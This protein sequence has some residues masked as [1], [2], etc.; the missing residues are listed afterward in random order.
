MSKVFADP[1]RKTIEQYW[2]GTNLTLANVEFA[3]QN[4]YMDEETF[5]ACM[6]GLNALASELEPAAKVVPKSLVGDMNIPQ[7]AELKKEG[8]LV[9]VELVDPSEKAKSPRQLAELLRVENLRTNKAQDELFKSIRA[10]LRKDV[11]QDKSYVDFV[12]LGAKM[13]EEIKANPKKLDRQP[14][15]A[16]KFINRMI[17]VYDAHGRIEPTAMLKDKDKAVDTSFVGIGT[18]VQKIGT[19]II[20]TSLLDG[21]PAKDSKLIKRND[22][23]LEVDGQSVE[24]LD[25]NKV[26]EKIRGAEG[27]TV[28]LLLLRK[29]EKI[30]VQ[31]T[32]G[33]VE[34]KNVD[35]KIISGLNSEKI[36]YLSLKTFSDPKACSKVDT[37]LTDLIEKG[38]QSL[39]LDLRGNP[40]GYLHHALCI[41]GLFVGDR[42]IVQVKDLEQGEQA[43]LRPLNSW[44][45][46][47]TINFEKRVRVAKQSAHQKTS[48]PMVVLIDADSASASEIISGALQDY[49]RAW[50]VG[51][52]TFGKG[53]VQ[54]FEPDD[55]NKVTAIK[56]IERFYRPSGITNQIVGVQADFVAPIK[57]NSTED[58]LFVA[59]EKD[60]F[61][62]S[63]PPVGSVWV[64]QR[65][66][67]VT[68][69]QTC[70]NKGKLSEQLYEKLKDDT[71][72]DEV[73]D[74]QLLNAKEVLFCDAAT[75]VSAST[76]K[77]T[78]EELKGRQL[79]GGAK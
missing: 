68:R 3:A 17:S 72:S 55:L 33:K 51:E 32:R 79:S 19:Q 12:T 9:Y 15:I 25:L 28:Q 75:A 20:V 67:D 59:R 31:I 6:A 24:G 42:V 58:E 11:S 16:A 53:S 70:L 29:S 35:G 50:L 5:R 46:Q 13:V 57:P 22:V 56:T 23:V 4:C 18:G 14:L 36:G 10:S 61:P 41:G 78:P 1:S 7:G 39:I 54:R 48:L 66:D 63:L 8:S 2:Q 37:A 76:T 45:V 30:S 38:A 40:G 49:K 71:E 34:Q 65:V 74:Y 26:V 52:T 47:E 77:L 44:T 43:L 73:P 69:I 64:Q 21:G 62:N 60:I 27:T